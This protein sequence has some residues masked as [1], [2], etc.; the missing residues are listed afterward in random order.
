MSVTV[1]PNT[2]WLNVEEMLEDTDEKALDNT[3]DPGKHTLSKVVVDSYPTTS[4][5]DEGVTLKL[6]SELTTIW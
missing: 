3:T 1:D 2:P 5:T 6:P 4:D